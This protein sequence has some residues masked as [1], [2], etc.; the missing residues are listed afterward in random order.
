MTERA[1]PT[2]PFHLDRRAVLRLATVAAAFGATPLLPQ[3]ARAAS[4]QAA[5]ADTAAAEPSIA[6]RFRDWPDDWRFYIDGR[7]DLDRFLAFDY[8]NADLKYHRSFVPVADRVGAERGQQAQPDLDPRVQVADF[9]EF[10]GPILERPEATL[11]HTFRYGTGRRDVHVTRFQ[12]YRDVVSYWQVFSAVPNAALTDV[13]HRAGGRCIAFMFNSDGANFDREHM[14]RRDADGRFPVGDRLADMAVY[15]GFDGYMFDME[16]GEV[17]AEDKPL[18][19]EMFRQMRARAAAQDRELYLQVYAP[20]PANWQTIEPEHADYL[21]T[22]GAADSWFLDYSWKDYLDTTRETIDNERLDRFRQVYFGIELEGYRTAL[23]V[24]TSRS[25]IYDV[26]PPHG[27]GPALGSVA[28]FSLTN[29][30]TKR[31]LAALK[32]ENGGTLPEDFGVVRDAV[33]A[34]ERKFWSGDSENP[35]RSDD[36]ANSGER[37]MADYVSARSS[38]TKLPFLT[39][40]NT[41]AADV[42]CVDGRTV[43]ERPWYNLGSQDQLPTWQFWTR[44][45]KDGRPADGPLTVDYHLGGGFNGGS[46][47]LISGTPDPDDPTE[48]RLFRTELAV[49]RAEPAWLSLTFTSGARTS[50]LQVGLVFA[51]RPTHTEWLSVDD[52]EVNDDWAGEWGYGTGQGGASS[53]G[54]DTNGRWRDGWRTTKRHN[55]PW[56]QA[57]F[58]LARH[59]GRTIEAISVAVRA[60]RAEPC[61]IALGELAVSSLSHQRSRPAAPHGLKVEQSR[62]RADGGS[63]EA[64]LTWQFDRDVWYYDLF[65]RRTAHSTD[66]MTWL[67]R[68][69]ADCYYIDHVPRFGDERSAVLQLVPV[70]PNGRATVADS[71]TVEVSFG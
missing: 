56:R 26:V 66:D 35:A 49:P 47:L 24:E 58:G 15:F 28:L 50:G 46:S 7:T 54:W 45:L 4:A 31:S 44:H 3:V 70:A 6:P 13:V 14:L 65:R 42:F 29:E 12:Q 8:R 21:T 63:A 36:E 48:V 57:V 23:G 9:S 55:T 37:G 43:S 32:E 61:R 19:L 39:R 38:I 60:R 2:S 17:A 41:G 40:F 11:A 20:T 1:E 64:R 5:A 68:V 67:G 69:T 34:G 53:G 71:A 22:K 18:V 52:L 59:A 25:D 16:G 33:Y 27:E 51:D 30:T 10:Y 62:V